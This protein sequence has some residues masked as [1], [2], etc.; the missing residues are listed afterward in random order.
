MLMRGWSWPDSFPP[1][2]V[3]LRRALGAA[4]APADA[5]PLSPKAYLAAAERY[6]PYRSYAVLHLWRH[7]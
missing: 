2:D 4:A 1:G 3:V 6:R 7:A 5:S